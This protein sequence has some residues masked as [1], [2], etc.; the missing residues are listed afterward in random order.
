MFKEMETAAATAEEGVAML[1]G[2]LDLYGNFSAADMR[3]L[4]ED[5]PNILPVPVFGLR[6]LDTVDIFKAFGLGA[7]GV[8]LAR[9]P[10]ETD[11]FPETAGR[12][13]RVVNYTH[14]LLAS[15][16]K[17]PEQLAVCDMPSE[18]IIDH[19]WLEDWLKQIG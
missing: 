15:L 16:G 9:A 2:F 18:G 11:P 13:D 5:Y 6:R 12:V 10:G 4:K 8:F 1:V 17:K 3:Q 19:A 7:A 14:E